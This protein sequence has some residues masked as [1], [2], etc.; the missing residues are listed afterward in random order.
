MKPIGDNRLFY[1]MNYLILSIVSLTCL[2]PL[3]NILAISL[4]GNESVLS[5]KVYLWPI[6]LTLTS[7]KTIL[8]GTTV[9]QAFQNSVIITVVGVLICMVFTL[10]AAYPLSRKELYGRKPFTLAIVFTMLF[11]GGLIPNYLLIKSL[12]LID[13][14]FALWL[15]SAISVY[16]M[17]IMKSYLENLPQEIEDSA[18]IDGA[19]EWTYIWRI[20]LPLSAPMLATI[21]LFYTVG[22]WNTFA[23]VLIYINDP[24]KYNLSVLVQHMISSQSLIQEF[25]LNLEEVNKVTP[26]GVKAAGVIV[27]ILPLLIVYPFIQKYFVKGAMIGAIKG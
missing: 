8:E 17:L 5:G 16:N 1:A 9:L 13:S 20:V 12:G 18:R 10:L 15:P 7:Y 19:G 4:S 3:I 24:V 11:T 27:L 6:D 2:Y 14:Y 25:S 21:A 23:N 22:L 26:E